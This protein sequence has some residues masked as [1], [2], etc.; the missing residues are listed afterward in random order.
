MFLVN[1]NLFCFK[2]FM[3]KHELRRT[4]ILFTL[5]QCTQRESV[6]VVMETRLRAV[7][8]PRPQRECK[9]FWG[10]RFLS[11]KHFMFFLFSSYFSLKLLYLCWFKTLKKKEKK[12]QLNARKIKL[13]VG[14][15]NVVTYSCL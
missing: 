13:F 8:A 7:A 15:S 14:Q 4:K 5:T 12:K 2:G 3:Q 11:L 9:K 10:V 1:V 6:E